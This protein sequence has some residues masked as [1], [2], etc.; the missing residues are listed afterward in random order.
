MR[1]TKDKYDKQHTSCPHDK[2]PY[3]VLD[4]YETYDDYMES[5]D[6]KIDVSAFL[7]EAANCYTLAPPRDHQKKWHFNKN[8]YL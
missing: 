6:S 3:R 7:V 8:W 1:I 4:K 2:C 5:E